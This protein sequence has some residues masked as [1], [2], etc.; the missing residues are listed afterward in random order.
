[1]G[2]RI[3]TRVLG[4]GSW[5]AIGILRDGWKLKLL[6]IAHVRSNPGLIRIRVR[7]RG[8]VVL[9]GVVGRGRRRLGRRW[10]RWPPFLLLLDRRA[11][12]QLPRPSLAISFRMHEEVAVPIQV[13]PHARRPALRL[14]LEPEIR[15]LQL[16]GAVDL[17]QGQR[18]PS[19]RQGIEDQNG[20]VVGRFGKVFG[21]V[22]GFGWIV[23]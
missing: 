18:S 6:L 17:L 13:M 10:R 7:R 12:T 19:L 4:R 20:I 16:E 9:L 8:H 14:T 15:I 22:S 3:G 5:R 1:M 11:W 2:R 23:W 21:R